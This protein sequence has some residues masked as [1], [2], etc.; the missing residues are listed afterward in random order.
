MRRGLLLDA[1]GKSERWVLAGSCRGWGDDVRPLLDLA[2]FVTTPTPVR[3]ERLRARE[4]E[5]F[6]PRIAEGGD[7]HESSKAFLAW[8]AKYDD[9]RPDMRSRQ[10]HEIWMRELTCRVC[11]VDGERAVEVLCGEVVNGRPA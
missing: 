6:G 8:A 10:L 9:A 11:R 4:A 7:M 3:M 2:I 5:R 1:L